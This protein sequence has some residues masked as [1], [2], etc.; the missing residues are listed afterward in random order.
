MQIATYSKENTLSV[1]QFGLS[2]ISI[3]NLQ[4]MRFLLS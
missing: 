3:M 1:K 2:T 4:I